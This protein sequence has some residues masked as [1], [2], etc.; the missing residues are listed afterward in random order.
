MHRALIA[1]LPTVAL[2]L[3]ACAR[4]L[5]WDEDDGADVAE[6]ESD[7]YGDSDTDTESAG[8]TETSTAD[9]P[10]ETDSTD[11]TEETDTGSDTSYCCTCEGGCWPS[12]SDCAG[13]TF[14]LSECTPVGALVECPMDCS[15]PAAC[16]TCPD[17]AT[18]EVEFQC[19][20][21]VD[22]VEACEVAQADVLG[23]PTHWCELD[24]EGYPTDCLDAC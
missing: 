4:I 21:W 13:E 12:E 6:S 11:D 23:E 3:S 9:L 14:L 20:A 22:G 18:P 2:A 5:P 10:S 15:P 1:V 16:C 24:S 19:W 7:E 8:E 17:P